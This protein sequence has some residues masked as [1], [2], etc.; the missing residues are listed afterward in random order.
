MLPKILLNP[1]Y[2]FL[3]SVDR[4]ISREVDALQ[5]ANENGVTDRFLWCLD[6][7]A[8]TLPSID[9]SIADLKREVRKRVGEGFPIGVA[10]K[11]ESYSQN[12]EGDVSQADYGFRIKFNDPSQTDLA[13]K[14]WSATYFMQSKVAKIPERGKEWDLRATF[15]R[16]SGQP[17]AI[18]RLRSL[19]GPRGLLYHL[20]CPPGALRLADDSALFKSVMAKGT[21]HREPSVY[22]RSGFWLAKDFPANLGSL[23]SSEVHPTPWSLFVLSHFFDVQAHDGLIIAPERLYEGQTSKE[24]QFREDLFNRDRKAVED[25]FGIQVQNDENKKAI[26]DRYFEAQP[27]RTVSMDI[28]FPTLDYDKS[29]QTGIA[30]EDERIPDFDGE[31]ENEDEHKRS[32][33]DNDGLPK[34]MTPSGTG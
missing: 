30:A 1:V 23:F 21:D 20:Y 31:A 18:D 15:T 10:F 28:S 12:Y 16:T 3:A 11:A 8:K 34:G 29:M 6:A 25:A 5:R 32:K 4:Y 26:L 2:R 9:F 27:H 17:E 22:W 33:H 7:N 24:A 14:N 13:I 19:V